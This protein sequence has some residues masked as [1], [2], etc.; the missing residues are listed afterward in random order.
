MLVGAAH[1]PWPVGLSP[2]LGGA[3][4]C[5]RGGT[6]PSRGTAFRFKAG[7]LNL[8]AALGPCCAGCHRPQGGGNMTGQGG[9]SRLLWGM[10][11]LCLVSRCSVL[12]LV[13]TGTACPCVHV[14]CSSLENL[15]VPLVRRSQSPSA[16]H[17]PVLMTPRH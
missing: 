16:C 7:A 13:L 5:A 8:R 6:G 15:Q 14:V 12:G 10:V 11:L 17:L 1:P 3:L 2:S 4:C 9:H